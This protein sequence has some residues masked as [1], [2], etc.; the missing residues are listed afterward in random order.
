MCR[1]LIYEVLQIKLVRRKPIALFF[2][3]DC[4]GASNMEKSFKAKE[5]SAV[6]QRHGDRKADKVFEQ[7]ASD[8]IPMEIVELMAKNQYERC[9]P[10]IEN[11]EMLETSS[12]TRNCQMMDCAHPY[13][14]GEWRLLREEI[15]PKQKSPQGRSGRNGIITTEKNV[16]PAK[17]KSVDFFSHIDRN[18]LNM[19]HLDQTQ[20]PTGFRAFAQSQ[21]KA[22]SGAQ[23][24]ATGSNRHSGHQDCKWNAGIEHGPSRTCL[25]TLGGYNTLQTVPQQSEA[26]AHLWS[27]MIPN[28]MPFGCNMPQKGVAQS[29]NIAML[30]QRPDPVH[31]GNMNSNRDPKFLNLNATSHEKHNMH[32]C[33]E[34]LGR[35]NAEYPLACKHNEM[36]LPQNLLGSLDLY[37]NETIPAMHLLSLMDAG[38][39]SGPTFNIVGAPKFPKRPSFPH[40]HRPK[41]F[42]RMEIGA[43]K[44]VDSMKQQL[45]EYCG[46]NQFSEK[47]NG[48][49]HCI[50]TVGASASSFQSDKDFQRASDFTGQVCLPSREIDKIR[51]CNSAIQIKGRRSEKFVFT[52][53]SLGTNHGAIPVHSVQKRFLGVSDSSAFTSQYNGME[54]S[55]Q[56]LESSSM[57]EICSVNKNP[58]D[59]ILPGAASMY[60]IRGEDLK[61]GKVTPQTRHG[62]IKLD[63]RKRQRNLKHATVKE[64]MLH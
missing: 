30:S 24:S 25:Q 44:T 45:P 51:S 48:C 3:Q 46:R 15:A 37:A 49:F 38:M 5:H 63:G 8:D 19:S 18:H 10:D 35:T 47:A 39:R 22:S 53:G 41:E 6:E 12:S 9:L 27:T 40:D 23:F 43:Y 2:W 33:S 31:D 29:T 16:G 60:M 62:L 20:A 34:T 61:L 17:K 11:K 55:A 26:A 36:G 54:S 64:R 52:T 4:S 28:Q 7:G 1:Q 58:A 56:H 14:S 13:S 57:H 50:P 42:P 59:F 32:C 21:K